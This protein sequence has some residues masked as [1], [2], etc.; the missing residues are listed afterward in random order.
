VKKVKK[1]KKVKSDALAWFGISLPECPGNQA[2]P[3]SKDNL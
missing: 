1:V 2:G 3:L